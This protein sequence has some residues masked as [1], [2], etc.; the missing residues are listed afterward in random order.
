MKASAKYWKAG[1]TTKVNI[2]ILMFDDTTLYCIIIDNWPVTWIL[3]THH[4]HMTCLHWSHSARCCSLSSTFQS[5]TSSW[6]CSCSDHTS[7]WRRVKSVSSSK[8]NISDIYL[9]SSACSTISSCFHMIVTWDK[10]YKKI[11]FKSCVGLH[12]TINILVH[13][14]FTPQLESL[15]LHNTNHSSVVTLH[16]WLLKLN[17]RIMSSRKAVVNYKRVVI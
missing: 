10:S 14:H 13:H 11:F 17:I 9:I 2:D 1:S 8:Y 5:S 3:I 12:L 4:L 6:W 7:L 16:H 15:T